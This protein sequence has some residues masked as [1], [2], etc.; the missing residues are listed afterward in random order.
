MNT[1][2]NSLEQY[3]EQACEQHPQLQY[4]KSQWGF[5]KELIS[6]ALQNVGHIF[7]H[8]SRHDVS[9]S[10]QIIINI[11]RLL[12]DKIQYLTATDMWLILEAAY[13]HDIGMVIT[14]KQIE[15]MN[16]PAFNDFV[17]KLALDEQNELSSFAKKWL[18][19]EAVLPQK[20][21]AHDFFHQYIQLLAE[22]YR[23]KHPIN[24]A[25][26]VRNP[27]KEIGLDSSRNEL[28]P[29][30]LFNILAKICKAHGDSFELMLKDLPKAEAGLG[31]EDCHPLYV[32]CL[33][34]MGDLLDIDDNR[35]CPVMMA[36]C[37]H[38][39]PSLSQA[40][41]DKHLSV[42][43][44]R[45]DSE[46]IE[47][48]CACP[49]PESYEAAFD[50]FEW[51]KTEYHNQTQHW[52]QIVPSKQLGRL[53]TLMNPKVTIQQPYI[54]I[55]EGKKPSFQ[56]NKE[57]ML[58]LI[59]G[60]GLYSSRFDSIREILQNAVDS[61]LHR[62][63][64]DHKNRYDFYELS[65]I[66]ERYLELVN[67]YK[68]DVSFEPEDINS[69]IWILNV[70]DNGIGISLNDLRYMLN[71]G[72]TKHNDEKQKRLSE[73]PMWFRPSGA[74]GIGLQSA[75][76]LTDEF[77]ITSYS[78]IDKKYLKIHFHK[79]KGIT[80][81][82][83]NH[84]DDI[85]YGCNFNVK[86]KVE[87][88]AQRYSYSLEND[89]WKEINNGLKEYDIT[90]SGFRLDFI[91]VNT[92]IGKIMEFNINSPVK[93]N[94]KGYELNIEHNKDN[95]YFYENIILSN[96]SFGDFDGRANTFF[97]GQRFSD[98]S[99]SV[100]GLRCNVDI[101][102]ETSDK[103]LSYNREKIL[104]EVRNS[105]REKVYDVICK[106]ISD[107]FDIFSESEKQFAALS[108]FLLSE[109]SEKF[110]KFIEGINI[111]ESDTLESLIND[112]TNSQIQ[113]VYIDKDYAQSFQEEQTIKN[114]NKRYILN[115]LLWIVTKNG[116]FYNIHK[117]KP[118][119]DSYGNYVEK[120]VYTF[121]KEDIFPISKDYFFDIVNNKISHNTR[122]CRMLFP[123]WGKFRE[124]SIR[125]DGFSYG[126]FF[127]YTSYS[128][129]YMILPIDF[130]FEMND[131]R[132]F[133]Y[134][135]NLVTWIYNNKK[136]ENV[137]FEK[138]KELV[139]EL[140]IELKEM[141]SISADK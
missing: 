79:H 119:K 133:D 60:T 34:R 45:L 2:L 110:T 42:Q 132:F 46:R 139:Q 48:E 136:Q 14:Q 55:D 82:E 67:K 92:I 90:S 62:I 37:S 89:M 17:K 121:S 40:H 108:Y 113:I 18:Q 77:Y 141:L 49:T 44:F 130:R 13:S 9:H 105:I 41:R 8:Y 86:I 59:R 15:E 128:T 32:A 54:I 88:I 83:L 104:P 20:A 138:I 31:T 78:I 19:D 126:D 35:F 33:L 69:D 50:W 120:F 25:N 97:R 11:E 73:M 61:T 71:V 12:G 1:Q 109:N 94:I 107:K 106:Y 72:S 96:L 103:F 10:K 52:D 125:D 39:L 80:I 47:V 23:R 5:D 36:M 118:K 51:L 99:L 112:V 66:D 68:V 58:Y 3:F 100:P 24:S 64:I 65:P 28:I 116:I 75:F 38:N 98:L 53:P 76:L 140:I 134:S 57:S 6:K 85:H 95:F 22:W 56:I 27:W 74:F 26:I 81:E 16:T 7:P 102:S 29:K 91:E 111:N 137:S 124:L 114:F 115:Y 101:Y 43:H 131:Q 87:K 117:E 84:S 4:L 135:E 123:T 70:R 129:D 30:R 21:K 127:N 63:W 93:V 122:G